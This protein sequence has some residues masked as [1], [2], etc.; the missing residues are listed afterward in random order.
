MQRT[1]RGSRQ[2]GDA[3]AAEEDEEGKALANHFDLSSSNVPRP[4]LQQRAFEKWLGRNMPHLGRAVQIAVSTSSA[5]SLRF[6]AA[7]CAP[8]KLEAMSPGLENHSASSR[9]SL[10]SPWF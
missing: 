1:I 2:E 6:F 10:R 4:P 7:V 9:D 8:R 5:R 3:A